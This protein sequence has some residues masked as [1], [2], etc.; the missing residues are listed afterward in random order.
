MAALRVLQEM[1]SIQHFQRLLVVRSG[2]GTVVSLLSQ[3][4][5][6]V[7]CLAAATLGRAVQNHRSRV[8]TRKAGAVP[9]L[10]KMNKSTNIFN[11]IGLFKVDLLDIEG[12]ASPTLF[13]DGAANFKPEMKSQIQAATAAAK[14]LW[15]L[16]YSAAARRE[17]YLSGGIPLLTQLALSVSNHST[18]PDP[19]T[20]KIKYQY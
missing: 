15:T 11:E 18:Q 12:R 20:S 7:R 2:L 17:L 16:C 19:R 8:I 10:V 1:A 3:P 9:L 4:E 14:A 6:S 13:D 5:H